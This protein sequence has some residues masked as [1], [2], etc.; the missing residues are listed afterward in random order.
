MRL[1]ILSAK[2]PDYILSTELSGL[3]MDLNWL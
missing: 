2:K 3:V 1:F